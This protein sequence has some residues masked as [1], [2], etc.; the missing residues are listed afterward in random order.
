MKLISTKNNNII[1]SF[2]NALFYPMPSD[3]G[4]WTFKEIKKMDDTFLKTL[5]KMSLSDISYNIFK[6]LDNN[7]EIC[8]NDLKKICE[9]TFNIPLPI[10]KLENNLYVAELFHGNTLAFK[11]FGAT[12]LANIM[13]Y[14]INQ[15]T[16]D[17][18]ILT[19][20]SGDT[21]GAVADAFGN[22]NGNIKVSIL[23]P[24]NKISKVQEYQ[25]TTQSQNIT[26]Y[27]I[28]GTFDHCQ[29]IVKRAFMDNEI[30]NNLSSANSIN[31]GRLI[32]Q[33]FYYFY[34]YANTPVKNKENIVISIPSGNVGN[35]T[36]CLIAKKL[37]LNI[38]TCIGACNINNTFSQYINSGIAPVKKVIETYSNA[39]DISNPSNLERI[40]HIYN[41]NIEQIQ[42][43][44]IGTTTNDE[45]TVN[46]IKNIYEKYGY[47]IDPHTAVAMDG[48]KQIQ[49]NNDVG[50]IIS[51]A[52]YCKF[53]N[54]VEKAINQK[55]S[56]PTRVD[57]LFS[58]QTNKISSNND[59]D[60]W[61]KIFM[62][63]V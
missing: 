37:G 42:Q 32:A 57:N 39:M 15:N 61:K 23:Y 34:I 36:G 28:D 29:D 60:E 56:L 22:T 41:N 30:N 11:D 45:Q 47:I 44:V 25:M 40:K 8:D 7:N 3:G 26:C 16:Q 53:L 14:F 35:I 48:F 24:K 2:K 46:T 20:T 59:Y 10:K 9:Q 33:I 58:K 18:H 31:I 5:H 12:F 52:H 17:I 38:K 63:K 27:E 43:D 6:H 49:S 51:T 54:I 21:G 4:L 62:V 55:L 50:I 19:A 1:S 13:N